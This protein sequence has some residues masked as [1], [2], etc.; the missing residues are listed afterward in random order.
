MDFS[1]SYCRVGTELFI[2]DGGRVVTERRVKVEFVISG[3]R[4]II[5]TV[6]D[7]ELVSI[8]ITYYYI[9]PCYFIAYL[10]I[11][12]YHGRNIIFCR[13][14]GAKIYDV[15]RYTVYVLYKVQMFCNVIYIMYLTRIRGVQS[16]RQTLSKGRTKK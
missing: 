9:I 10:L 11:S 13:R 1:W 5:L 7:S 14:G 12:Y 8:F 16:C 15:I 3:Y 4:G 6:G 2:V